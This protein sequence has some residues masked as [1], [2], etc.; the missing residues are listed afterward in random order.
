[1]SR[2]WTRDNAGSAQ[3]M[4]SRGG[5]YVEFQE[6][7]C[8]LARQGARGEDTLWRE[9]RHPCHG[10]RDR[11]R[12]RDVG[13][14]HPA[15]SWSGS[16]HTHTRE[17]EVFRVIHGLYRFQCGDEEFDAPAGSVVVLPPHV[18]HGWRNISDKPGQMFGIVTPGGCEQLFIDIEAFGADTPAKIAVIEARLGIINEMTLALGLTSP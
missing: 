15:G 8:F 2:R 1:M 18:R 10:Q 16:A 14:L 9:D 6:C 17:T 3:R 4:Q 5:G 7:H 12:V 13:N 11:W